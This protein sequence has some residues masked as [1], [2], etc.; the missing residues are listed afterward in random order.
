MKL[1]KLNVR[2]ASLCSTIDNRLL[3]KLADVLA[4]PICALINTSIRQGLVPEQWKLS[5]ISPIPKNIPVMRIDN[6][7]R[8]IAVTCPISKIA[9]SFVSSLFNQHFVDHLDVNQHGSTK[10]RSTVTALIHF[11]HSIFVASDDNRN[12]IRLLFVDF[13]K[14]FDLIDH[15]VL[16]KKLTDLEFPAHVRLWSLA[17]VQQRKQ[18]VKLGNYVSNVIIS[19]A[20]APQ[21]T[22]AGPDDFKLL[23]NDL[24]FDTT[25][26]KYVDDVSIATIS[27]DP[28]NSELQ[29]A[30]NKLVGWCRSN[31][32]ALNTKK[33]KELVIH[34]GKRVDKKSIPNIVINET[35]IDRVESF[36]LLGVYFS[37]DL[38]WSTHVE[39][40]VSKAAR[41]LFVICQLVRAGIS[42][43]DIVLVYCSLV[44]SILEYACPVWH[45]GLK[46]S[47]SLEI[48][49]VQKRCLRILYPDLSYANALSITGLERL[50]ERRESIV[51]KLFNQAK[52]PDHDLNKLLPHKNSDTHKPVTR[53]NYP[54]TIPKARTSRLG[55]SFVSYCLSKRF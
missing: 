25:Y 13:S 51:R 42:K 12:I 2:K 3:C 9:E 40:I 7:I 8:P 33:T 23:I 27:F 55:H 20:G 47:Q 39:Y 16:Y 37:S 49:A 14:A 35:N 30:A 5:R 44:R 41:R 21:G 1:V 11:S 6:D 29:D 46:K 18:F 43:C 31:G 32:M 52:N 24:R 22:L 10:G 17:F 50:D 4:A 48:E 45:C 15:S 53:D 38:S 19:N 28:K 26:I 34:F 54:Y 36:K